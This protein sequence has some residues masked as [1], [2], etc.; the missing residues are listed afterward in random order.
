MG[1]SAMES[2]QSA[3]GFAPLD[4][5]GLVSRVVGVLSKAI[6][7]RQ[8]PP[9][10][11]VSES[12][13]ARDMGISRAPVRE[14]ARLLEASGLVEYRTNRGFFVR[15]VTADELDNLYEL[16]MVIEVAAARRLIRQGA[17]DTVR[18][19]E[20]QI[21]E[22]HR[23]ADMD[24]DALTQVEADME[25]HR[26]LCEGSGNP[27]FQAVFNQ[28]AIE[29]E[30][31]IMVVGHIYDDAHRMADTHQPILDAIRHGNEAEAEGALRFH[32]GV[33]RK[34]V[35]AQFRKIEEGQSKS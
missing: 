2:P 35:T 13:I 19:L 20:A 17:E 12:V 9:G 14:A 32:I 30:F 27:K 25:F 1:L 28:I 8:L 23:V 11:R 6:V 34:L 22:L 33:A 26:L 31:S 15:Q 10:S 5:E 16:R 3:S 7:T 21:A 4:P 29:T 24:A 18:R